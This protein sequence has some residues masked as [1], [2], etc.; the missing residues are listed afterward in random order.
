MSLN[1]NTCFENIGISFFTEYICKYLTQIFDITINCTKLKI[2]ITD[3]IFFHRYSRSS[4]AVKHAN[5]SQILNASIRIEFVFDQ[6]QLHH[7]KNGWRQQKNTSLFVPSPLKAV[8]C[9]KFT[10]SFI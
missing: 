3:M 7:N 9:N 6:T 10:V 4:G 5:I 8:R 1:I 2:A